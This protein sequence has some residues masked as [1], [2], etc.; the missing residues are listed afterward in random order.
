MQLENV[1]IDE[2]GLIKITD[3]GLSALPQHFR[4]C[5]CPSISSSSACASGSSV[6]F[7]QLL[8]AY[9]SKFRTTGCCILLV[10]VQTMLP[11]KFSQ[12]KGTM[13]QLQIHGLVGL[14]CMLY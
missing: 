3:F 8:V 10:E 7:F 11:L 14:S 9:T 4:V 13:V 1:L 6:F 2:S 5:T 12:I